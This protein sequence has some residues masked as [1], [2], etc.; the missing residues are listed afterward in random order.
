MKYCVIPS[1]AIPACTLALYFSRKPNQTY[2]NRLL[3]NST[4]SISV[5]VSVL[6]QEFFTTF[7]DYIRILRI[8]SATLLRLVG[9]PNRREVLERNVTK[10][11]GR[12]SKYSSDNL[13][14]DHW[15]NVSFLR[16]R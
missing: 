13:Q 7:A 4:P 2:A 5:N 16:L 15:L 1:Q 12:S 9:D 3:S 8:H 6:Y 10:R 11:N 14:N